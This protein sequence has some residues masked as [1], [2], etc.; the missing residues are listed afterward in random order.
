MLDSLQ[1]DFLAGLVHEGMKVVQAKAEAKPKAKP[2]STPPP[3]TT[4][5]VAP[6]IESKQARQQKS[7]EAVLG[8]GNVSMDQFAQFLQT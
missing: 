3:N 6:P 5:D 2:K 1:G 4:D 8:T 7:K